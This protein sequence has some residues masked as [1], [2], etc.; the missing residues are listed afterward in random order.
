MRAFAPAGEFL[1]LAAHA[2]G[3]MVPEV[4]ARANERR[5]DVV[6]VNVRGPLNHHAGYFDSYDELR[7][8]VEAALAEKPAAV[9]LAID[10]PG[11]LVSGCFD[12]AEEIRA[13]AAAAGVPLYA[14]VDGAALSA[15]Y[16]LA[17]AASRIIV[18][19]TGIVGSIGVM[20]MRIDATAAD[21]MMGIAATAIAVGDRKLDGNPHT[22]MTDDELAATRAR[23]E[24]L[25]GLFFQHVAAAR[26]VTPEAVRGLKA[27]LLVGAS[28][29]PMLADDVMSLDQ[30]IAA[31]TAGG[32]GAPQHSSATGETTMSGKAYEEAISALRKMAAGDGPEAAKAKRMLK[33]ELEEDDAPPAGE[34]KDNA[35]AAPSDDKNKSAAEGDTEDKKPED[36]VKATAAQASATAASSTSSTAESKADQALAAVE[37]LER[38]QLIA[39]RP[40]FDAETKALLATATIESVREYVAKA[41]RRSVNRAATAVVAGTRAEGQGDAAGA[42]PPLPPEE[43]R[44]LDLAMGLDDGS[45]GIRY[46]GRT[47]FLGMMT[48]QRAR[49]ELARR[50]KAQSNAAGETR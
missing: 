19:S 26:G 29:V 34:D 16:A 41:P 49:E 11:G 6:V 43:A 25:A 38:R 31:I 50:A 15:G 13:A 7:S 44:A 10:S 33:A 18:P 22:P 48:R 28:A 9:V 40:D 8:R 24:V 20:D 14:F 23:Q 27:A 21:R 35:A 5:G 47:Q 4:A 2:F 3:M 30:M 17:C 12:T 1:A 36:K 46:E 45:Q 39:S 42:V 32:F 37:N